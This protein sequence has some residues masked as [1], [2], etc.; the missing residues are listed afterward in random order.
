MM[1]VLSAGLRERVFC[2]MTTFTGALDAALDDPTPE[3]LSA[4]EAS[5]DGAMR[6]VARVMLEVARL[7]SQQR[8]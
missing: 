3:A 6:A 2:E 5:G 7:R 4:L 1:N 8:S